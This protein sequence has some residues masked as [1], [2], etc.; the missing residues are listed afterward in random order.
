M[1]CLISELK[2][3]GYNAIEVYQVDNLVKWRGNMSLPTKREFHSFFEA[4]AFIEGIK[5]AVQYYDG[6]CEMYSKEVK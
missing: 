6:K 5:W 4:R 1:R 2:A 3:P